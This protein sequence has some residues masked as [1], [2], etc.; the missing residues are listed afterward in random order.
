MMGCVVVRI[1]GLKHGH[2]A[3]QPVAFAALRSQQPAHATREAIV[4]LPSRAAEVNPECRNPCP[5]AFHIGSGPP[6]SIWQLP[7]LHQTPRAIRDGAI[8]MPIESEHRIRGW[9][10]PGS[11][12]GKISP[13]S[14]VVLGAQQ[15]I[16]AL[17]EGFGHLLYYREVSRLT[18]AERSAV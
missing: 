12:A 6:A 2:Q 11:L 17:A 14:V 15:E 7:A 18:L 16:Q 5:R 3:H 9:L 8:R 10:Q 4:E 1:A 13:A